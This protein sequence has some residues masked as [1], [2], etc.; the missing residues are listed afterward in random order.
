MESSTSS[1]EDSSI[2]DLPEFNLIT[3]TVDGNPHIFGGEFNNS[4][5]LIS[6]EELGGQVDDGKK[7][8]SYCSL[9]IYFHKIYILGAIFLHISSYLYF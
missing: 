7:I 6:S 3:N 9:N 8:S 1:S 4:G 2:F 5:V